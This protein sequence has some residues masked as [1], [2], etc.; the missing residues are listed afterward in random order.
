[1]EKKS[2]LRKSL[3][4]LAASF[5]VSF[6]YAAGR[7]LDGVGNVGLKRFLVRWLLLFFLQGLMIW[8]VWSIL[9][10]W[11][12]RSETGRRKADNARRIWERYGYGISVLFL[13]LC[14]LPEFLSIFPGAFSY[15][16]Y[17]EWQQVLTGRLSAHHP[18]VHVL[19]LGYLVEWGQRL[20]GSYNAGIACYS[21]LQMFLLAN[22]F[23]YTVRFL[24]KRGLPLF[25]QLLIVLF[26]GVSPVFSMFANCATKDTLFAASQL[27]F[28]LCLLHFC[29]E[30]GRFFSS[31]ASCAAFVLSALGVMILRNNGLYIAL[32]V[33]VLFLFLSR[34]ALRRALLLVAMIA[35]C[36]ILYVVPCYRA[37]DVAS[38]GVEEMLSVPIQQL[39][40]VHKYAYDALTEED[41]ALLYQV[42]PEQALDN[43]RSTVSDFVKKDFQREAFQQ[44]K[45]AFFRLWLKLGIE[46]PYI[47]INSFLVNTVDFWYPFAVID[48]Y[49]NGYANYFDYRVAEPGTYV[50][51][52]PE[53]HAFYES[54]SFDKETQRQP[55]LF[56]L[57]SPG[58]YWVVFLVLFAYFWYRR[59]WWKLFVLSVP[60]LNMLTVLLGPMALVRYVLILFYS[61][62]LFLAMALFPLQAR[63]SVPQ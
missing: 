31:K 11:E 43:Y 53:L 37:L 2:P 17:D 60:L 14:W 48:G 1:M 26:Y 22:T 28:M 18:I 41:K 57:L 7:E 5:V 30:K 20:T 54:L 63:P 25:A 12:T 42:L 58:W 29:L 52:V 56:L 44:N 13:M 35:A 59:Q 21:I 40:R 45:A 55:L 36:Y 32:V 6:F 9:E 34:E 47:Y 8:L 15:D 33:L 10:R 27:L 61:A 49:Q 4:V 38:G 39:A 3:F 16:A 23:A 51:I 50:D 62:P 24:R 46:H 19:T